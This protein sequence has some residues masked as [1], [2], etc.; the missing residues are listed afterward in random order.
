M[1]LLLDSHAFLWFVEDSPQISANA[2]SL[3]EAPTNDV[4][5]SV[6][7]V[8][9]LAIKFSRGRLT[10]PASFD[11][12][13]SEQLR[14]NRIGV[15]DVKLAHAARVATLPHHHRDPFDRMLVAQCLEERIPII[16]NDRVLDAYGIQRLW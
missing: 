4:L 10:L 15:L 11:S 14:R 3:I 9:E 5:L 7:S 2:L 1:N 6:A 13:I 16:S 12:F 8:W